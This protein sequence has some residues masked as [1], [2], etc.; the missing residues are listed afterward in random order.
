MAQA[1]SSDAHQHFVWARCVQL[2]LAHFEGL[3]G[4]QYQRGGNFHLNLRLLIRILLE[5]SV[6]VI[7]YLLPS[8][9]WL[10]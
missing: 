3:T 10:K 7:A 2:D 8:L 1:D 6:A 5:I 9:I 4:S